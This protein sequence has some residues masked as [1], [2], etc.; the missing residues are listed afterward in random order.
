M[1]ERLEDLGRLSV[2]LNNLLDHPLFDQSKLPRRP[3]DCADWWNSLGIC[4]KMEILDH[5]A[6]GIDNL[7][8]RLCEAI[9]IAD[10][11]DPLNDPHI[12]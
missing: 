11:T 9:D 6:Y 10:G 4:V 2:L 12:H 5:W 3:K 1:R 8:E 7:K